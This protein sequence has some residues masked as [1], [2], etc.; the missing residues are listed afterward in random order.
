MNL[1]KRVYSMQEWFPDIFDIVT[2]TTHFSVF[3]RNKRVG[4]FNSR[5]ALKGMRRSTCAERVD[6]SHYINAI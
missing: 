5:T 6:F 2:S 1:N 4:L 3:Q